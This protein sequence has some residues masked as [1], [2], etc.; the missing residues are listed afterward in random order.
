MNIILKDTDFNPVFYPLT[1]NKS[2]TDLLI[3]AFSIS[4]R[5]LQFGAQR[6]SVETEQRLQLKYAPTSELGIEIDPRWIPTPEDVKALKNLDKGCYW[7]YNGLVVAM[8]GSA[9]KEVRT[10]SQ[11]VYIDQ[12]WDLF[13]KNDQ[14]A[15][16]DF[17]F[18][19]EG[20][21][22]AQLSDT[23]LIIGDQL[24][25]EEGVECEGAI[26]NCKEGPVYLGKNA[27]VLEG[28]CIR[29]ALFLLEEAVLKMGSKIYG[30]T[31]IGKHSKVGGEVSNA[32]VGNYSNKGHEGYL[33]NS[34][35]GEWCNLGADTN[36]SNLKNN[37][38]KVN[39]YSYQEKKQVPTEVQ[40][41]GTIMGDHSKTGINT[42]LNTATKVGVFANIFD[43]GFPSKHIKSF[44]W[45]SNEVD[46]E[47]EKAVQAA[48]AMMGRRGKSLSEVEQN[49]FKTI[50][51]DRKDY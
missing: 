46:F 36:T 42:M 49:I 8:N 12:I 4:E 29:G 40:F 48:N 32:I 44:T 17:A 18:L 43:A 39:V 37:Y 16:I 25:V 6:V 23:N 3:G 20:K 21:V 24:F 15:K 47:W 50:Y 26:I 10:I 34:I 33:G 28:T 41:M 5:W 1:I 35:L 14:V 31:S 38:S 7:T 30:A 22:S 27:K 13:G 51:T 2:F 19:S 9:D 45:G 11:A